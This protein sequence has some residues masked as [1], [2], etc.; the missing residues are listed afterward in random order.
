MKRILSIALTLIL[1]LGLCACGKETTQKK[2]TETPAVFQVGFGRVNITPSS[3]HNLD[4][5]DDRMS[6]GILNP[7]MATC[8]AITD[9]EDNTLLLYTVDMCNSEKETFE[10]LR[11]QL[12][13]AT[14]I[15]AE[16]ITV[17][18]THTHSSPAY[19]YTYDYVN[20]LV[21]AGKDAL[22]DRAPATIQGG[23]YDVPGMNFVRHYIK[24]DGTYR[25][26]NFGDDTSGFKSHASDA[27]ESMRLIRFVRQGDKKDVLMVN[28]QVHP[29]L[30]STSETVDG[31]ATRNLPLTLS[32]MPETMWRPRKMC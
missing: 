1:V 21:Q 27:D 7:V 16:N 32:A 24:N 17:S 6:E 22:A 9:P 10:P 2:P 23:S 31:R 8:V 29:K 18:A 3:S 25:G 4:G 15:P 12:T 26:D 5:Y 19:P 13:E 20:R 30:A 11:E 14:G 28:W